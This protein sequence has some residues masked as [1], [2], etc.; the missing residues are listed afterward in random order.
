MRWRLAETVGADEMRAL[1][2][3]RDGGEQ[4][5]DL[6][7][8]RLVAEHGQRERRLGDEHI[9]RHDFEGGQVGSAARL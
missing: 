1:G 2:L 6:G 4:A 8:G 5:P 9:A 3:A 7:F